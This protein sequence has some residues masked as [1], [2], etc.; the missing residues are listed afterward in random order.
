MG[1]E[2]GMGLTTCNVLTAY[3]NYLRQNRYGNF[4]E[5]LKIELVH[6]IRL[7]KTV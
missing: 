6:S 5:K 1:K 4:A 3:E 2:P 7:P